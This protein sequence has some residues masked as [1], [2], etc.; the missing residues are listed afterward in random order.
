MR[1]LA[2]RKFDR[3]FTWWRVDPQLQPPAGWIAAVRQALGMSKKDLAARLRI[4]PSAIN[5]L[6]QSER[7]GTIQLDTLRRVASALGCELVVVMVP[8]QP[9]EELVER[10]RLLMAEA[11]MGPVLRHMEL[12]GQTVCADQVKDAA[13]GYEADLSD[14]E[15]WR[16]LENSV[17]PPLP[18]KD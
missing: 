5:K 10:Q 7:N 9:L 12:E 13:S 17:L 2:R 15:L 18:S 3:L 6:E 16:D 8:R 11:Q 14:A 1:R 4:Y